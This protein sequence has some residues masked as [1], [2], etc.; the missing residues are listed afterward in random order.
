[1]IYAVLLCDKQWI[2]ERIQRC[3]PEL[4]LH[5]GECLTD[6]VEE[7]EEFLKN[8]DKQYSMSVT[9]TEKKITLAAIV[10][11]FEQGNLVAF[12][13]VRNN[14]DF[15][16]FA[17]EYP[18]L[19]EWAE[20]RLEGFYH[21]EYFQIQKLNNQLIDS[22]RALV[23]SKMNLE[24]ALKENKEINEKISAARQAAEQA[25]RFKTQFLANMSH[26]IRTPMNAIVGLSK[27]M[28]HNIND[29]AILE[30]Y[31][32]KL[33]SSSEYLLGLINDILD[34]SKIESGSM[35]LRK[36]P[37]NLKETAQNIVSII[38]QQTKARNQDL[39]IYLEKI[40]HPYV[41]GDPVRIRQVL[42][43]LLSNA[44]KYTQEGGE[45]CLYLEELEVWE[46]S[47]RYCF[48]VE[49]TGM[50]MTE[51]FLKHIFEPFS[52]ESA[53]EN[54]IQGTGLGM[55]ITK[56]IVDV[57]NGSINVK[58]TPGKGSRFEVT[59]D[60]QLDMNAAAREEQVSDMDDNVSRETNSP[61]EENGISVL[62]GMHFLCAEDNELNAEIL[63]SM[64]EMKGASCVI[65]P[66]GKLAA[67]AFEKTA[68]GEYD[69]ILMD[70]QMPVMN[71]YEASERIR[72]S[73]NPLG[74]TI[75]IIAM[76]ANAFSEDVKRSLAAGMN[77][78][79]SKPIEM[80][81]L[82]KEIRRLTAD[83]RSEE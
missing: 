25:N 63:K 73:R 72:N 34:L 40:S 67:E 12:S 3:V 64:L 10:R 55:A 32:H 38:R 76:T 57:M 27:L 46:E 8:D 30:N 70:V 54:E 33:Q 2:I 53:V 79:V 78:H 22:Q 75:P 51:E 61:T 69:A 48:V 19:L 18:D 62:D 29:P 50:G 35:E 14:E 41:L 45:V 68:P 31:I 71:G 59:L 23:R 77:A 44:A 28:E 58:S 83:R 24:L 6:M 16:E 74:K 47:A 7:A 37:V 39:K 9:F 17:N 65:Y 60:M 1:M 4:S 15:I 5:E 21:S 80:D 42:M 82:E 49:D 56:S 81:L 20:N 11:R 26:D 52:R 13:Y 36:E 43:N 66:N